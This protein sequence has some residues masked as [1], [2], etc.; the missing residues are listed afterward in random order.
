MNTF[1][2]LEESK[3]V[4]LKI[5]ESC[6]WTCKFCHNEWDI[7]AEALAWDEELKNHFIILQKEL[8]VNEVHLTGWEP[9]LNK[10]IGGIITWLK[11][12]W[13]EVK[14][15]TNG[16]FNEETRDILTCSWISGV[17]FSIQ[18]IDPSD[19][20]WVMDRNVSEE[21]AQDQIERE[22]ENII[23]LQKNGI[24]V[25]VNSVLWELEDIPRIQKIINWTSEHKVEMRVLGDLHQKE[26]AQKAIGELILQTWSKLK[27]IIQSPWSS[28]QRLIY[29]LPNKE[30]MTIK[31]IAKVYL[32]WICQECPHFSSGTCQ[33]GFYSIRMQ[34]NRKDK[35]FTMVLCIQNQN[36]ETVLSFDD[37]LQA[38]H[39]K[40]YDSAPL[41][42]WDKS[43]H[44]KRY[45]PLKQ[46]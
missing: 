7:H 28:N 16:Q 4:R 42:R 13:M 20:R 26:N 10:N 11:A 12:I 40:N 30:L 2:T 21:W 36:T 44:R 14:M 27:E 37:F 35:N 1:T 8:W 29:E 46:I 22:M 15:T 45:I 23:A 43:Y 3:S 38:Y 34:K 39:W 19:L 9:S 41:I 32:P 5:I 31:Q 18:S 33:E 24:N 25:R 17:N 6:N